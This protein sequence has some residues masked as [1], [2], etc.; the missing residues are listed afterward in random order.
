MVPDL[1]RVLR[2]DRGERGRGP[3]SKMEVEEDATLRDFQPWSSG[4]ADLCS[5][6]LRGD[7]LRQAKQQVARCRRALS[8]FPSS[9][10]L[11]CPFFDPLLSIFFLASS[12]FTWT[13]LT[14]LV[15]ILS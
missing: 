8:C 2:V 7:P 3:R 15:L 6:L 5:L 4:G 1:P 14:P 9:F 13:I 10:S 12:S 11:P